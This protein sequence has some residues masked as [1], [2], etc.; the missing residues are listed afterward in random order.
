VD[1]RVRRAFDRAVELVAGLGHTILRADPA[2][3][4]VST[5]S[6][7]RYLAGAAQDVDRLADPSA[8]ERR[9][10]QLAALGRRVP[11]ALVRRARANGDRFGDRMRA[12]FAGVDVLMTPTMPVLPVAAGRILG[13]GLPATLGL[14]APRAAFTAPW[15][16]CGFPAVSVPVAWTEPTGTAPDGVPV[17]VQLVAAPGGEP[18]LLALAAALE[19][20]AGWTA[21]RPPVD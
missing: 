3:G 11:H 18:T 10:A 17:G 19:G 14:M 6:T 13:R 7:T 20:A 21:R 8:V 2:Y 1:T 9:T 4:A 12:L 16:A 15:N 5:A